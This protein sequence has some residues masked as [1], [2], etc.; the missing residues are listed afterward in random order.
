MLFSLNDR[1]L[2]PM[3]L[4]APRMEFEYLNDV[5]VLTIDVNEDFKGDEVKRADMIE[6]VSDRWALSL[7]SGLVFISVQNESKS[8]NLFL[9]REIN[10]VF[11]GIFIFSSCYL[12]VLFFAVYSYE[13]N[14][15]VGHLYYEIAYLYSG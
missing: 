12:T 13:I 11:G 6:K 14:I 9:L 10:F 1:S 15:D 2:K 4:L 7:S 3:C 8:N 5:P